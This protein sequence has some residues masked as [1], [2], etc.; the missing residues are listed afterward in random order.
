[1]IAKVT[2]DRRLIVDFE[3]NGKKAPVLIDTGASLSV[4]DICQRSGY[5]FK[6]R[7]KLGGRLT[8]VGG[9]SND[10]YHVKD[11]DMKLQGLPVYQVVTSDLSGVVDSIRRETGVRIAGI[12]GL[13]H[14]KSLELKLDPD[15]GIVKIGY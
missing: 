5:K 4:L 14:I 2:D 8:G 10:V 11:L 12:L 6:P 9:A 3:I 7:G 1:M 13:P 15:N